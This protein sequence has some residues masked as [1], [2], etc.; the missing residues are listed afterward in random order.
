MICT[1]KAVVL[2]SAKRA[3]G[4]WNVKIRITY[5]RQSRWLPTPIFVTASQLTRSHNLKDATAVQNAERYVADIRASLAKMPPFWLEGRTVDDAVAWVKRDLSRPAFRLDFFEFGRGIAQ[6]KRGNTAGTYL[7]ALNAFARFLGR[8]E[9]D[10]SEI[11]TLLLREFVEWC[12]GGTAG[13]YLS[14]LHHVYDQARARY[15]D[16][17]AGVVRIPRN[18]F[19]GVRAPRAVHQGASPL[20]VRVMQKLIDARTDD[21]EERRALDWFVI[22]FALMGMNYIDLLEAEPPRDGELCY[23]R[24]KTARKRADKAEMRIEV[25]ECIAPFVARQRAGKG[26]YWLE[27]Q[28]DWNEQRLA[29][30]LNVALRGWAEREGVN[31]RKLSFYS[32]RKT[33]GTVARSSACRIDDGLIDDCLNHKTHALLDVY[34]ERD[35]RVLNDANAKVLGVF[36]WPAE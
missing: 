3:D 15:N 17:D 25:P 20:P 18:P 29:R 12:P 14:K 16:E 13:P 22:S 21:A 36:T 35:W 31:V 5:N 6:T 4:T 23:F 7:T 26:R 9:C 1:V 28:R 2:P 10:I 11:T 27:A 24:R 32:A 19:A 34:A 8:E 33:W 30:R